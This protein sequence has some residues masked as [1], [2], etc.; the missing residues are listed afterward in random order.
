M[1]AK[2]LKKRTKQHKRQLQANTK[3]ALAS[4][5]AM[6]QGQMGQM[7]QILALKKK[8]QQQAERVIRWAERCLTSLEL[9]KH[10]VHQA[11][12]LAVN[13]GELVDR[14]VRRDN[15]KIGLGHY[16]A[17]WIGL[18]YLT[19]E[20][21][22]KLVPVGQIRNWNFLASVVNTWTGMMMEHTRFVSIWESLGGELAEK[23][24]SLI[25]NRPFGRL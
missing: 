17:I 11:M 18:G 10:S 25:F 13:M 7:Q 6:D 22:F 20:A 21:R 5:A 24:W 14:E 8:E 4:I 9:G 16:T 1:P 3:I 2:A 12:Q 23:M 19:D 15:D